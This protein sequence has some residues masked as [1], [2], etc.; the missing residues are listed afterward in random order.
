VST[1]AD[2][3]FTNKNPY[4]GNIKKP[5]ANPGFN[6]GWGFS[7]LNWGMT[8]A[9]DRG[10]ITFNPRHS[11]SVGEVTMGRLPQ[12][13]LDDDI[14]G[15]QPIS[16]DTLDNS[17]LWEKPRTNNPSAPPIIDTAAMN[18]GYNAA[19]D[20]DYGLSSLAALD[21]T[22]SPDHRT[23]NNS[24]SAS[25]W[26][27]I[28]TSEMRDLLYR[29]ASKSTDTD[30]NHLKQTTKKGSTQNMSPNT[31]VQNEGILRLLRSIETLSKLNMINII[32]RTFDEY[33]LE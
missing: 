18:N 27:V 1:D 5:V 15:N 32:F 23:N 33:I 8:G 20:G 4:G 16:K 17:F 10:V 29:D 31:E 11:P 25:Q 26:N 12:F 14:T 7:G 19:Y 9:T 21:T 3:G 24:S 13:R 2:E 30:G 28:M 6:L 22:K